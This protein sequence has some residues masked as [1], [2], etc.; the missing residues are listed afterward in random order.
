M[1]IVIPG[2]SG[3]L[4]QA[5]GRNL[6]AQ[7]HE[8]VILSRAANQNHEGLRHVQWDGKTL[9]EWLKEVDGADAL[10]NCTG[11]SVNCIYNERNRK[12]ILES[13]IHSVRVLHKA[14]EESHRPPALF[15]QTGSLAI[16]GDSQ[17]DCDESA[18]HGKG[19]SVE[20]CESWEEEFFK[21]R[22]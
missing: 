20:V 17:S 2:G 6:A 13:R 19:F 4:G 12:E 18:P 21:V 22:H 1:K 16:Y 5:L 15:C 7:G 8:V 11:K 9:G 10:F 3:F 14:I